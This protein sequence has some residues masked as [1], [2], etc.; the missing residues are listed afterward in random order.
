MI[1][2][3]V[4]RGTNQWHDLADEG[5]Y[6]AMQDYEKR[7]AELKEKAE[8]WVIEE[9]RITVKATGFVFTVMAA[10]TILVVGGIVAGCL[11]GNRLAGVDPF[12]IATFAWVLAGFLLLVTQS[13][14][15]QEWPWRDFFLSRVPCR[16][17]TELQAATGIDAQQIVEFLL[18]KES[19]TILI[20]KGP[21]NKPFTRKKDD[22]F[23]IDVKIRLDTL[24]ASGIIPVKVA[25]AVG[26]PGLACLDLREGVGGRAIVQHAN[27][28]FENEKLVLGCHGR[29]EEFDEGNDI[30]LENIVKIGRWQGVMGIYHQPNKKFR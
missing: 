27:Y 8:K 12:N 7:V 10:S 24:V 22:A 28:Y 18:S 26:G 14:R 11:I 23:S 1:D 20:T 15:V 3:K 30:R 9:T 29:P 19:S 13:A 21:F 4:S 17:V 16:S 6:R 25:S 2:K 5:R